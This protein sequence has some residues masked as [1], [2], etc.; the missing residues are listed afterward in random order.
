LTLKVIDDIK[1]NRLVQIT[2]NFIDIKIL[3]LNATIYDEDESESVCKIVLP[4]LQT[5][6]VQSS[7]CLRFLQGYI[8]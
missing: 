1:I 4:N 8:N 6:N 2:K 7:R 3:E 5:L